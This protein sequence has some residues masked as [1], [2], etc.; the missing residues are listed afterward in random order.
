MQLLVTIL[1][2]YQDVE[3]LLLGMVELDISGSTVIEAAGMGSVLGNLPILSSVQRMFP[4]AARPSHVVLT[5]TDT[6]KAQQCMRYAAEKLNLS[7]QSTTGIM[8]V[9]PVGQVIGLTEPIS[10]PASNLEGREEKVLV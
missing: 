7:A 10:C 3:T 2:D 6:A 5:V 9:V 4:N 1:K 8:F